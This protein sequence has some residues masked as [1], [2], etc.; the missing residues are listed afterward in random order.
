[1]S[2]RGLYV[3]TH[4]DAF[5]AAPAHTLTG[6]ICVDRLAGVTPRSFSDYE[7]T[8]AADPLPTGI[9]LTTLLG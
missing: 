4:P 6:R 3:F 5:G 2:A 8:V 7:V 1:M 9:T